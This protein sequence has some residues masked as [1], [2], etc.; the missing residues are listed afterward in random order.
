MA[1]D[2]PLFRQGQEVYVFY[3][4]ATRCIPKRKY[5]AVLDPR[6]GA[7]RPRSG[8]S[9]GWVPARVVRDYYSQSSSSPGVLIEYRW[10]HF[11]TA[12]GNLVDSDSEYSEI[13]P[14]RDVTAAGE[15][16]PG[17]RA[18]AGLVPP[19]SEP[20]L[21]ILTF[22]WGGANEIS[23]V[24][25]WGE[26]G[27]SVSDTFIQAFIDRGVEPLLGTRYEVWTV[28]IEDATDMVKIAD[29]AHLIFGP[30]HPV[31]RAKQLCAMYHLY[32]TCFEENCVPTYNTGDDG[33]AA[34]V[35]QKTMFRMIRSVER[36]GIPTRFPH[37]SNLYEV[38]TSKRWT[39]MMSLVP[40]LRVPPTVALPRMLC[41]RSCSQAAESALASLNRVKQQQAKLRGEEA[42]K[43]IAKGVAKLGFSWEA[44]DVE[45][46]EGSE[47]LNEVISHLTYAVEINQELTGQPQDCESIMVQE[48]IPHDL[49]MRLYVVE[50]VV[51]TIIYTKF[52]KIKDNRGFGDFKSLFSHDEAAK[53]WMGG[54][55]KAL[56]DGERQC[57]KLCD[58]W[59]HW[60]RAQICEEPPAIRFDFFVGRGAKAGTAEV[61]TLEICELGFSMLCAEKLPGKVFKAMM[62]SCIGGVEAED[63]LRQEAPAAAAAGTQGAAEAAPDT[64][65]EAEEPAKSKGSDKSKPDADVPAVLFVNVPKVAGGTQD[66]QK[67]TGKY[68]LVPNMTPN[69]YPVWKTAAGDRWLYHGTANHWYIGD[70]EE[71]EAEFD[72][73][74]GYVRHTASGKLPPTSLEGPWERGEKFWPDYSILVSVDESVIGAKVTTKGKGK[75]KPK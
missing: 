19:G 39:Y 11:F 36:A 67:C 60:V 51:D 6:H 62:R 28:Y 52:C 45:F 40:H 66:Q 63:R 53:Q 4:Q 56:E 41:E 18:W 14:E 27:T 35:D 12:R 42:P 17:P 47:A 10:P 23:H 72:C 55:S 50:G 43:E 75:S 16:L 32:P 61:W 22:R 58:H 68:E 3:R 65:K 49:E 37:P 13:Y 8:L 38:L 44:L 46:W 74:Q 1:S 54:D 48:Y 20:E 70:E 7:Y 21:A 2:E 59:M 15:P 64:K 57:R 69:G 34:L 29:T 71:L 30:Q 25:Q 5:V 73:N 33:G 31:R 9:D 24:G 26:T